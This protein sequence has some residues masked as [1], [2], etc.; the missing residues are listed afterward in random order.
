MILD[1]ITAATKKRV[2]I[3]KQRISL[4]EM[5]RNACSLPV[6]DK[7]PFEIP[8]RGEKAAF[9]CEIKKA[10]PSKGIIAEDF[11]YLNIAKEYEEAGAD[12]IS[13][14]T[15][16]D[17]FMG[18]NKY[19]EEIHRKVNTPLLRKDFTVDE[20]MIYEAKVIGASAVLLICSLLS[21]AVLGE[22]IELCESLGLS[23]LVEAHD[24]EEISGGYKELS[25]ASGK[26]TEKY[27][28]CSGERH[29]HER[30]Y[31]GAGTGRCERRSDR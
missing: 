4:E 30:R 25:E 8:L 31:Q 14:L 22:W 5:K 20:Y 11:P 23:A 26:N 15:E 19:L 16:P 17:Y 3:C 21:E 7:F 28:V 29:P 9:I 18:S 27:T 13:V 2:E 12:S 10:S 24:E 1:E 6:E